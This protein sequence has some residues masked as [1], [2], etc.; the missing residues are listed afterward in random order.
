MNSRKFSE[1]MSEVDDRYYEEAINYKKNIQEKAHSKRGKKQPKWIKWGVVAAALLCCF[2]TTVF[3]ISLFSSLSGDDLSLSATYEGNGVVFIQVENRSDKEL[4]FQST[5]KLMRWSTSEEVEPLT[6]EVAFSNTEI[7]AH[8]SGIMVIDLSEAYDIALLETPL[9]DDDWYYFVLTNNNFSFGQ[10]WMCTVEF[11]QSIPTDTDD[12]T[13]ISPADADPE[14]M[15]K[16]T[17][18]LRPYFESYPLDIEERNQL[19]E[20]YLELCRQFL[21]QLNANVVPSVSPMELTLIDN[22]ESVLFDSTVPMDMQLQLTGLHRRSVDG[23]GKLIGS[24]IEESAMVLSAYIPQRKG[25]IDGG[26]DIPLIYVLVYD[27]NDIESLQDYAFIRGQLM[28]FEQME[29]YKIYEDEQYVCYDTSDL[30]YTDLRQY[31]ESMVSQRS[32]VYFDEQV[33]ERVQNI[34]NYYRENMGTLLGYRTDTEQNPIKFQSTSAA[35]QTNDVSKSA[36]NTIISSD[37]LQAQIVETEK[38]TT[39]NV[40]I[41]LEYITELQSNVSAAMS[42]GEL[43]FVSSSAVYENPYRLH[44]TVSSNS[45]EDLAKL[46]AFDTAGGALEI[47]YSNSKPVLE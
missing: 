15:A 27:V 40:T 32:D 3:A 12:Q 4:H 47:E 45:E 18:E 9:S 41:A 36:A 20:E 13:V 24:S 23:Y 28:T 26:A 17:E 16:I 5:L 8:S 43:P 37:N 31:V 1:A 2:S 19:D 46:K 29:Q 44:V 34:Y 35:E 22:D 7:P 38:E 14:L 10:D 39:E 11:A 42:K 25:E 33:W 21:G 6:G 30:F